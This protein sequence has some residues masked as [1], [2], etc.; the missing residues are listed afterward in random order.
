MKLLDTATLTPLV[1]HLLEYHEPEDADFVQAINDL[2]SYVVR[3]FVCGLTTQGYNRIFLNKLVAEMSEEK[4]ADAETLRK[5]LLSL[6]GQ[7][8]K[9]PNDTAPTRPLPLRHNLISAIV[10]PISPSHLSGPR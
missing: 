9:W 1:F 8:Q 3:R 4:K 10:A 2:E 6:S 5:K 7:S